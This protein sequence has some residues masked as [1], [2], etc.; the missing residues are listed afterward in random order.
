MD[1][2]S[3][4]KLEN[5]RYNIRDE[6]L[7]KSTPIYCAVDTRINTSLDLHL[8]NDLKS[9]IALTTKLS[10]YHFHLHNNLVDL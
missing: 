5:R 9:F 1:T 7:T 6:P 10:Y 4:L 2:P 8:H 3:P